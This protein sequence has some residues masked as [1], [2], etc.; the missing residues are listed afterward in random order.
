MKNIVWKPQE[1]QRIFLSR[2]E[3][4]VL[5]GGAAGGGKSDAAIMLPLQQIHIPWF[6]AVIIRKTYPQLSEL[7]DKAD[8][9]YKRAFPRAKYNQQK[10]RWTFPSGATVDF[11]S[12]HNRGAR[13]N[14][15][16]KQYDLVIFDEL[17]HFTWDEYSFMFSRNRPSGPGT[18]VCMRSTTNPGG[19]G[20]A[21][22]KDRFITAAPPMTPVEEIVRVPDA[23]GNLQELR[24]KRIFVP[25]RVFDNQAL[26]RNDPMYVANL[27]ML[28]EMERKAQLEGSW[29]SFSGQVFT[30]W[31]ND[32]NQYLDGRW[33]HV[34][35]PYTI[36][37]WWKIYRGFD[38]GF[39]KPFAVGWFA[40]DPDGRMIMVREYY[41]CTGTPN[42]GLKI[43]SHQVAAKIRE[44]EATDPNIAGHDVFGV[45]DPTIFDRSTG[46]S[47]ADSMAASPNYVSWSPG[48]HKR[49]PGKMQLHYRLAFSEDGFPM[50]QVFKTCKHFIRTFPSLV[51]SESDVEDV[52]TRQEDHA[53]DMVRYVAMANPIGSRQNALAA[54]IPPDDPLDLYA[55]KRPKATFYRV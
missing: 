40:I 39:A 30:E 37:K 11:G 4:E 12:M 51:Y 23:E 52:D 50:L 14:F 24:R 25:A 10:H 54:P 27:G 20:H 41:G 55:D 5:Y 33:T 1:K 48:D 43:E 13:E 34:I 31:I 36:P 17:T 42:E 19:I 21:W 35:E 2:P 38:W 9:Y 3:Y 16:G 44:I 32:P 26:L 8:N 46:P 15:R 7:M 45:A 53:Y 47:V 28:G 18:F 29:D 6:K 22:V 49:I